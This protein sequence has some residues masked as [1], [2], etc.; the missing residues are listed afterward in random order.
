MVPCTRSIRGSDRRE[1]LFPDEKYPE[2]L[3][4]FEKTGKQEIQ[5]GD[6]AL[7]EILR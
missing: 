4:M 1:L 2:E 6:A 3:K 5:T 7:D